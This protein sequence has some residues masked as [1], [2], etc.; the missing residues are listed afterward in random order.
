MFR[1]ALGKSAGLPTNVS[2]L[3]RELH[4]GI[5]EELKLHKGYERETAK[6]LGM[7]LEQPQ[8]QCQAT[9]AYTSFLLQTAEREVQSFVIK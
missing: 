4:D 1:L 5:A 6:S 7:S 8:A 2:R 3:L 9:I